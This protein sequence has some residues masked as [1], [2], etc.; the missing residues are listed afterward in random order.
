MYAIPEVHVSPTFVPS[1][2]ED[3]RSIPSI[4][5]SSQSE[6][7]LFKS[8][9]VSNQLKCQ[10]FFLDQLENKMPNEDY[11]LMGYGNGGYQV[12]EPKT[13]TVSQSNK[14]KKLSKNFGNNLWIAKLAILGSSLIAATGIALGVATAVSKSK[15]K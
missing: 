7:H 10:Q 11:E 12:E 3:I 13:T 1:E 4:S 6:T 5:T 14:K 15:K 8:E 2:P 9:E